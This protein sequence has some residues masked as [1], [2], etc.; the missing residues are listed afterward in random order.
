[1]DNPHYFTE[2]QTSGVN[3]HDDLNFKESAGIIIDHVIKGIETCQK[4]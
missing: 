2:N 1:M 3:P 4:K